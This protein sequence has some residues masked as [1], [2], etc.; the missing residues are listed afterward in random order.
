MIIQTPDIQPFGATVVTGPV[1]SDGEETQKITVVLKAAYDLVAAGAGPRQ[2]VPAT[3]PARSAITFADEGIYL[4]T[5]T[6]PEIAETVVPPDSFGLKPPASDDENPIPFFTLDGSEFIL[7]AV[8]SNLE[9]SL[10]FDLTYEADIALVKE[11]TD[12]VVRGFVAIPSDDGAVAIDTEIWLQRDSSTPA[13]RDTNRNLFGWQGRSESP[14]REWIGGPIE[15]NSTAKFSNVYRR[16]IGFSTPDNRNAE[17]L[18]SQAQIDVHRLSNGSD[19]TY[20]FILPRLDYDARYRVYCGH[21]PDEAP[22][23]R[24]GAIG[25]MRPDTLIVEPDADTAIILWRAGWAADAEPE[26]SY[27]AVQILKGQA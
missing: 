17:P 9:Q 18:P 3:D 6:D 5:S 1:E 26:D 27:R 11:S 23:W 8:A 2:M 12:I 20:S 24:I 7:S 15:H 25:P 10:I 14:R 22:Y 4:F 16:S 21:G 19:T 13:D